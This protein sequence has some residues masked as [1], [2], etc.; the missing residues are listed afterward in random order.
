MK[1][2]LHKDDFETYLHKQVKDHRMY[3]ADQIWRNIQK[4]IHG[5]GRWPALTYISIFIITAL[6][7]STMMVK[8]EERLYKNT[9]V[10]PPQ[11]EEAGSEKEK[12]N[13]RNAM[14]AAPV[15]YAYTDKITQQTMQS[16]SEV[17]IARREEQAALQPR[18]IAK[19][20]LLSD[21]DK[22]VHDVNMPGVLTTAKVPVKQPESTQTVIVTDAKDK[23]AETIT[24]Y[25]A[26]KRPAS[27]YFSTLGL[28][29]LA[30]LKKPSDNSSSSSYNND[31]FWRNYP[32]LST[33]DLWRKKLSKFSFQFY[34]TPSVSSRRLTDANGKTAQSYTAI[35]RATNYQL[36]I[37]HVVEHRPSMGAEVGFALGY[38]LTNTLTAKAGLQFNVRQYG[39]RAYTIP[40]ADPSSGGVPENTTGTTMPDEENTDNSYLTS[41][42]NASVASQQVVL[43]NRYYEIAIPLSID[44]R[45]MASEN[46]RLTINASA[47]LQ[48]TYTFDKEPFV[49][50]TDYKS[51]ADG[52]SIMRNWNL[53]S[54]VEAYISYKIGPF[55][56]QLG[57]QFRYQH[58][59]TYSNIYPIREH[60]LDYGVKLGFTKSLD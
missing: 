28:Q 13:D 3:P 21:Q 7:I 33:N 30:D 11:K 26:A 23:S 16:V 44:W 41:A 2:P 32:L 55:R 18:A 24:Q 5:E 38:K 9:I 51:Y 25:A 27:R 14:E 45:I 31:D 57:P 48:P 59:S 53:N 35:P 4:E 40:I 47:S 10:Y 52:A 29:S 46:G 6:A 49:I 42:G 22:S 54:N 15:Q 39:I 60:L 56:W 37:N 17:I 58:F 20:S 36:D 19:E 50:T 43:N 12:G 1:N 8:P 34:I